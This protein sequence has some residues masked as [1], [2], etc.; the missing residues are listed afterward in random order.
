M[1]EELQTLLEQLY[2]IKNFPT[3]D[4]YAQNLADLNND[5]IIKG[6]TEKAN[7]R[8]ILND[9]NGR[10]YD[11]YLQQLAENERKRM[12][13][14]ESI[15]QLYL[16]GKIS[17]EMVANSSDL[18]EAITGDVTTKYNRNEI[19]NRKIILLLAVVAA[20]AVLFG[21]KGKK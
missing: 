3:F 16:T 7:Y 11:E 17:D 4:Q 1:N 10:Y 5:G 13:I 9:R 15:K 8:K 14:V 18:R 2:V 6:T 19:D 20:F 21:K 12:S